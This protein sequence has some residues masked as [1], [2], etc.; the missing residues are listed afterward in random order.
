MPECGGSLRS[1]RGSALGLRA[2]PR[3]EG[4]VAS[5]ARVAALAADGEIVFCG[6]VLVSR[7]F[8]FAQPRAAAA[9]AEAEAATSREWALE[10]GRA[11]GSACFILPEAAF[12]AGAVSWCD[13]TT[14]GPKEE[15]GK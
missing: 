15:D 8:C 6:M 7:G 5:A 10:A 14:K 3:G 11:R 9:E 2:L 12:G 13:G 1:V 4:D